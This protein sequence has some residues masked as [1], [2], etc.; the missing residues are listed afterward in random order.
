MGKPL[1]GPPGGPSSGPPMG[2][3]LLGTLLWDPTCWTPLAEPPWRTPLGA[4]AL[5]EPPSVTGHGVNRMR[6]SAFLTTVGAPAWETCLQNSMGA[7]TGEPV[8]GHPSLTQPFGMTVG[9][10]PV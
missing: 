4:P 9:T 10:R 1:G 6:F 8:L 2:N 7:T 3:P 5:R